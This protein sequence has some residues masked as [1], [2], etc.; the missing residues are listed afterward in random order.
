MS[1]RL[2]EGD[3]SASKKLNIDLF[4]KSFH[5]NG[6]AVVPG[7]LSPEK[8]E[9]T[10]QAMW[11]W[12]A[13]FNSG[14]KRDDPKT[15]TAENW[16]PSI[17][18]LIQHYGVGHAKFVWEL[19]EELAI[20]KIFARLH[21]L[22]EAKETETN[23]E[24][25]VS[26]DGICLS[27]PDTTNVDPVRNSWAHM[28]QGPRTAGKFKMVQ[29]LMTLTEAGPGKGG[30]IV[31]KGSSKLHGKFFSHFPEMVKKIGNNDWV[32]LDIIHRQWYFD[33]QCEELQI[34]APLG[35]L[36]LWDSRCVHWAARPTKGYDIPRAAIYLCYQARDDA[37]VKELE[38][39]QRVCE[40]R[41]MTSH[42]PVKSKLFA[43]RMRDW[44]DKTLKVR[45]PDQPTIQ[46][47]QMTVIMKRLAGY[48]VALLH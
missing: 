18:G 32:K 38:K 27:K 15:W 8:T 20:R 16:P 46:D 29:G 2:F 30:L 9:Q 6:Y 31:Y 35:S 39:K 19:R 17:R 25:L 5:E 7:I 28:D 11:E 47:D 12:M 44:G 24:L 4:L 14:I 23:T 42:W 1:K 36:I 41:R 37:S 13:G 43:T 21:Q 45:F 26:F 3:E 10:H 34:E 48:R 40:S 22:D 33:R